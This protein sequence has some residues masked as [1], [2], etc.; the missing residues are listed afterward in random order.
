MRRAKTIKSRVALLVDDL[1]GC[2]RTVRDFVTGVT[3]FYRMR[4]VVYG[5]RNWDYTHALKLL[6]F[7]LRDF[8]ANRS[9]YSTDKEKKGLWQDIWDLEC[10]IKDS[11]VE[12]EMELHDEKWGKLKHRYGRGRKKY[13]ETY[14]PVILYRKNANTTKKKLQEQEERA[15]IYKLE[16]KKKQACRRRLGQMMSRRIERY[17]D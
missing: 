6:L 9:K 16:A 1:K 11:F 3:N 12:R 2:R 10:M 5:Y 4:K 13:G 7:Y 15:K 8:Q 14:F 17:W